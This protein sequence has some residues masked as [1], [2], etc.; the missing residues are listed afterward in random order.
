VTLREVLDATADQL[1]V[2]AAAEADGGTTW[3]VGDRP[4]AWLDASWSVARFRLD[5]VVAQAAART[6]DTT[7]D[8]EGPDVVRFAPPVVDPHAADRASA[9]FA[10]AHRRAGG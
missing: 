3:R 4:F 2:G 5:A 8:P 9:W 7:L 6:P 10:A 1:G